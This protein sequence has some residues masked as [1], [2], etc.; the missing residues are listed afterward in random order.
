MDGQGHD[1]GLVEIDAN[2]V[3][4]YNLG[5][6]REHYGWTQQQ[7][8]ERLGRLTGR[9]LPQASI[10]AMERGFDSGRRR[11]FDA[12]ELYLFSE[13]YGVPIAYFFVPPAEDATAGHVL[14]HTGRSLCAL[15]AA[16]L[17]RYSQ[18]MLLDERL[19]QVD[20]GGQEC[21]ERVL[22]VLFGGPMGAHSWTEHYR[23]WRDH[24]IHQLAGAWGDQLVNAAALLSNFVRELRAVRP[25]AFLADA[26]AGVSSA[27]PGA[28]CGTL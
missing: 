25:E 14:A 13:L 22:S 16:F 21:T 20:I 7:V 4:S 23:A 28:G 11:R 24:R 15:Y 3:V 5:V 19:A 26:T 27:G 18:L 8:A 2:A 10:S 6:I 1:E 12:H 9:Q 17:G